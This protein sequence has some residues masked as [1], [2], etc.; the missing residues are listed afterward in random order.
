MSMVSS[1]MNLLELWNSA[2]QRVSRTE[3]PSRLRGVPG[4]FDRR[5]D[6][7]VLRVEGLDAPP[8]RAV[9]PHVGDAVAVLGYPGGGPLTT[10]AAAVRDAYQALGRDI[11]GGGLTRRAILELQ[12]DV[13]PG[14]SGGPFVLPDGTVGGMVFARSVT[15]SRIGYALAPSELRRELNRSQSGSVSTGSCAAA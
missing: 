15:N 2:G 6:V 5:N 12:A 13:R 9:D 14:N 1:F 7:A 4:A 3:W 8:L 11:Y 10:G